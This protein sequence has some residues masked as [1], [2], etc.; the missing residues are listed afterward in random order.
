VED[1]EEKTARDYVKNL[2]VGT[3][4]MASSRDE[5][6]MPGPSDL[7]DTCDFC[8]VEKLTDLI[9]GRFSRMNRVSLKA[10]IGTAVHEKMER[11]LARTAVKYESEIKVHVCTIPGLGRIHGHVDLYLPHLEAVVDYKT[12]K[13]ADI[14]RFRLDGPPLKHVGQTMMY[15][16]G[17][18]RSDRPVKRVVL[19]YIPREGSNNP[20]DVWI[21]SARYN[22]P[23]A[24]GR[25]HR[26]STLLD[27]IASNN[28]SD[29]TAEDGCFVCENLRW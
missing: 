9:N 6:K 15:G 12:V 17:V 23:V 7:S 13:L 14:H 24:L 10:W 8:V 27:K 22:E 19:A 21:T 11:D 1:D 5:Q 2:V 20:D 18:R 29:V 25:I 4:T 26:V 3:I 28:V 16:Y